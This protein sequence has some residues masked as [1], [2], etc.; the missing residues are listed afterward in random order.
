MSS[1][2]WKHSMHIVTHQH[3]KGK[4]D[5]DSLGVGEPEAPHFILSSTLLHIPFPLADF[6]LY[7]S[8]VIIITISKIA[9][10]ITLGQSVTKD[11]LADYGTQQQSYR[12]PDLQL[13]LVRSGRGLVHFIMYLDIKSLYHTL[14]STSVLYVYSSIK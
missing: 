6:N 5:H 11:L 7:L 2:A 4:V 12:S 10:S 3:W 9:F 14:E 1:A 13:T 8:A